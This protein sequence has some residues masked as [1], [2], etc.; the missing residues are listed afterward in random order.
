M[1]DKEADEFKH[2]S[3]AYLN[4]IR[5]SSCISRNINI[6]ISRN[7]SL[8]ISIYASMP[9]PIAALT[10]AS[11]RHRLLGVTAFLSYPMIHL[12]P[13]V[14]HLSLLSSKHLPLCG[15]VIDL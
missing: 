14:Q 5:I 1:N 15:R 7:I 10:S 9:A 13:K 8:G 4:S 6:G 12:S 11:H 3:L 2:R